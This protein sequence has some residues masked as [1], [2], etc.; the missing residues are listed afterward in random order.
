LFN[1][2]PE[3]PNGNNG[4]YKVYPEV[5]LFTTNGAM[6]FY[7]IDDGEFKEYKEPF[8]IG[9]GT[10]TVYTYAVDSGNNKGDVIK[11]EFM[12]DTTPPQIKFDN[13]NSDPY[14]TGSPGKLSGSVSEPCVLKI[15]DVILELKDDLHFTVELNV[16]EGMPIAIYA[17]DL[18]G[19]ATTILLTAH[20]DT[21]P[22]LPTFVG[23]GIKEQNGI[24]ML[25]IA[26][27]LYTIKV[28]L[29]EA[30]KV[31]V[32]SEEM[33]FE[34]SNYV[35]PV[36]LIEGENKFEIKAVDIAGN[37]TMKTLVIKKVS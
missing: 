28:K 1:I 16:V 24:F 17:R 22:P 18:A 33:N 26:E 32:N 29:N 23:E 35:L 31:F 13:L 2:K 25:E 34:G 30:G 37:E 27:S 4:F 36:S 6:I 11:K 7:K 19:N 14:F 12:V 20:I 21:Q 10:H 3:S 5:T 9:E 15:N 8:K